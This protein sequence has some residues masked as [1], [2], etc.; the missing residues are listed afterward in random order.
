MANN[1]MEEEKGYDNSR[2]ISET[3]PITSR[4]SISNAG[5]ES[6][7]PRRVPRGLE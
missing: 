3:K 2:N 6:T 4:I 5:K 1:K 7:C